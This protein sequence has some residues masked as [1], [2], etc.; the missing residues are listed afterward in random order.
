M[1]LPTFTRLP[2]SSIGFNRYE[3]V[4]LGLLAMATSFV[5]ALVIPL[6][7]ASL[8]PP[9]MPPPIRLMEKTLI[10]DQLK[11]H[12]DE[13]A[14]L[15]RKERDSESQLRRLRVRQ[16][17]SLVNA[18]FEQTREKWMEQASESAIATRLLLVS[19]ISWAS[20]VFV[21]FVLLPWIRHSLTAAGL[22]PTTVS[23]VTLMSSIESSSRV[24]VILFA[25][26]AV[27]TCISKI[28]HDNRDLRFKR[29]SWPK[30]A[31]AVV[32]LLPVFLVTV[33]G[34]Y[35]LGDLIE[36]TLAQKVFE[37]EVILTQGVDAGNALVEGAAEIRGRWW[38]PR[39]W[40]FW[41]FVR[42]GAKEYG[43]PAIA[44]A[45]LG[46]HAGYSF[47]RSAYRIMQ[48]ASALSLCWIVMR[49]LL[50]VVCRSFLYGGGAF[51]FHLPNE[52]LATRDP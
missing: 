4:R 48:F 47:A 17:A 46:V 20:C 13:V 7:N 28:V 18:K 30:V 21:G 6:E 25:V 36:K 31:T 22:I 27:A 16:I 50:F 44:A 19:R 23:V 39:E 49:T 33:V 3:L 8:P 2:F 34:C 32:V 38:D 41:C 45:S 42:Q 15:S 24:A 12:H 43:R 29:P 26:W 11:N 35:L 37:T 9:E 14:A 5:A 52:P 51:M 1:R 40:L 10:E